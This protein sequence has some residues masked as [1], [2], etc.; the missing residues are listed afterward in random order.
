MKVNIIYKDNRSVKADMV[1][2]IK[3][4]SNVITLLSILGG[5]EISLSQIKNIEIYE[6]K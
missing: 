4:E 1:K 2:N 6:E 3:I 5:C